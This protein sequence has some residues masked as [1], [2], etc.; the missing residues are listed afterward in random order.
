MDLLGGVDH[1]TVVGLDLTSEVTELDLTSALH[2][3]YI[4]VCDSSFHSLSTQA[5][6]REQS[7]PT[8]Y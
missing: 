2:H 3:R 6:T 8:Y 5:L 1:T 7:Q 4:S